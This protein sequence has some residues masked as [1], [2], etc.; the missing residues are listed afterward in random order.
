MLCGLLQ[1]GLKLMAMQFWLKAVVGNPTLHGDAEGSYGSAPQHAQ[2][3][4]G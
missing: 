4:C 2:R 1:Q 3:C